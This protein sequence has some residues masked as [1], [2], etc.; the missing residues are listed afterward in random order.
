MPIDSMVAPRSA[1]VGEKAARSSTLVLM[2]SSWDRKGTTVRAPEVPEGSE[3]LRGRNVPVR[4][5]TRSAISTQRGGSHGRG[6]DRDRRRA[7]SSTARGTTRQFGKA[8]AA[9]RAIAAGRH[10]RELRLHA[11]EDDGGERTGGARGAD[12]GPPG[13]RVR[14]AARRLQGDHRAEGGGRAELARRA[15][16]TAGRCR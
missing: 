2:R 3:T 9:G 16:G 5:R 6:R 7:S 12:F 11:D 14:I 8:D 1:V 15:P 13:R 10:L 4:F